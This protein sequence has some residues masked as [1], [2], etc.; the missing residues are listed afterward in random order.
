[1]LA[2]VVD[3][4]KE[5]VAYRGVDTFLDL[6]E[7]FQTVKEQVRRA[8]MVPEDGGLISHA[9]SATMSKLLVE[10]QGNVAGDD[11][12]AIL[13]RT[14]YRLGQ[15]DL[16]GATRELNQLSGWPKR[17]AHDWIEAARRRLELLQALQVI[18]TQSY[19]SALQMN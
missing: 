3:S 1:M 10:K 11:V 16:D 12:E 15:F 8:S 19:L 18:E 14:E 5:E 9:V 4:I 17:L 7:R 6:A 13:A 2:P